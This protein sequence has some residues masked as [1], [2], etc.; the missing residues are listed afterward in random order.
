MKFSKSGTQTTNGAM[1][2]ESSMAYGR[3]VGFQMN[4]QPTIADYL[5]MK[6]KRE[7]IIHLMF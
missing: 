5:L 2:V 6:R 1:L 7:R 3:A 4:N